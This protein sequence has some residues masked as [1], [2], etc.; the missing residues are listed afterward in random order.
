VRHGETV[1]V[2]D[3]YHPFVTAHGADAYY[4]NALAGDRRTMACSFDPDL[5]FVRE[6]WRSMAVDPR[7]PLV[8]R[9]GPWHLG[10]APSSSSAAAT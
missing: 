2:T 7:V 6:R 8:D 10:P 1:I 3:D 5:D 4:L 9:A